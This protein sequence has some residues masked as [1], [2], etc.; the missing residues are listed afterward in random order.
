M[1]CLREFNNPTHVHRRWLDERSRAAQASVSRLLRF[2][3]VP[4]L[5]CADACALAVDFASGDRLVYSGDTMPCRALVAAGMGA[6][7]LI[8]EVWGAHV[9]RV[10]RGPGTGDADVWC[11]RGN[12]SAWVWLCGRALRRCAR[13]ATRRLLG[14]L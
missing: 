3:S 6:T 4:V 13:W 11:G 12:R 7:L 8:H 9:A 5:H 14:D 10:P 2:A 1:H